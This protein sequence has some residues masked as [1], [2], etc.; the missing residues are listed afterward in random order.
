MI[1]DES[2]DKEMEKYHILL[3]LTKPKDRLQFSVSLQLRGVV[4]AAGSIAKWK[5]EGPGGNSSMFYGVITALRVLCLCIVIYL[6]L[7]TC[8]S[9]D[10]CQAFGSWRGTIQLN[11][12]IDKVGQDTSEKA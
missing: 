6:H 3:Y 11:L 10:I 4:A 7:E 5:H 1:S 9:F 12:Y 8:S 2:T